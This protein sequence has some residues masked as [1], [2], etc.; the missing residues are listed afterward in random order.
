MLRQDL[1]D[2]K[3]S[4]IAH[5]VATERVKSLQVRSRFEQ[6]AEAFRRSFDSQ[7]GES[8]RDDASIPSSR[9]VANCDS[10]K[11]GAEMGRARAFTSAPSFSSKRSV[12]GVACRLAAATIS[13]VRPSE[14]RASIAPARDA[15]RRIPS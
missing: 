6:D 14:S 5:R 3:S 8:S 13:G 9:I 11:V 2:L 4:R 1:G 7:E 15:S 10:S 12:S